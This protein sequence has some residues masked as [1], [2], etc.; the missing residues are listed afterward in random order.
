MICGFNLTCVG[1]ERSYSHIKS[2]LGNTLADKAL[3]SSLLSLENVNEYSFLERGSD[4]RQ[5]CAP[6]IDLPLCTFCRSMFGTYSEY[7]TSEDNFNVV[8]AKGLKDSFKII[9]NIIDAFEIGIF[10]K[11]DVLGEPQLGKRNLY[12]NTSNFFEGRHPAKTRMDIIAYC[13]SI[14]N[15]FEIAKLININ[16]S[17]VVKEIY[18]LKKSKLIKTRDI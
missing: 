14:H 3:T 16:L 13:D 6:G 1:D 9:K 18:L 4:E 15:I 12:P 8:T 11:I 17:E 10:P 5:Y 2:R 7:H